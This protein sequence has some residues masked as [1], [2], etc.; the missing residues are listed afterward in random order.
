M[1]SEDIERRFR[2]HPPTTQEH[3]EAHENTREA[4]RGLAHQMNDTLP[5]GREKSLVLTHLEEGLMWANAALARAR[6]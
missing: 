2:H 1:T 3:V 4:F 5:E 6:A